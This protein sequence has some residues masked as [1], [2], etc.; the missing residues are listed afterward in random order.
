MEYFKV[1]V[2]RF[3]KFKHKNIIFQL[4]YK[5]LLKL[6]RKEINFSKQQAWRNFCSSSRAWGKPYKILTRSSSFKF[7]DLI[8]DNIPVS[9]NNVEMNMLMKSFFKFD[10]PNSISLH[11]LNGNNKSVL[12]SI[13]YN[14]L[15]N[16]ITNLN[17]K[18]SSSE[19]GITNKIIKIIFF[20][21]P[22]ILLLLYNKLLEL[23]TFP[24]CWKLANLIMC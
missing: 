17:N 16:I 22:N 24:Q 15:K 6:Y 10:K 1:I 3:H 7:P 8:S 13:T 23:K 5:V 2:K 9:N 19:D 18:K 12:Y 4:I 11:K 21:Y 20:S 14:E